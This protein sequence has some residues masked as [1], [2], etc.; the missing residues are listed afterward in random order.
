MGEKLG[1]S[2]TGLDSQPEMLERARERRL[3]CRSAIRKRV[4]LVQGD[5]RSWK[6]APKFDLIVIPCSS[7][8]HVL[9]LDDQIALWRNAWGNLRAGGRFVIEVVMPDIGAF[10]SS[11]G[12][13]PRV[14][15]E[16]DLDNYDEADGIRLIRRKTTRYLSHEQRAEIRFMYEKY[17]HG[18]AIGSFIDDFNS[19]VFFPRELQ[20]LFI[21]TGFEIEPACGDYR[22]RPLGTDSSLIIITGVKRPR[23]SD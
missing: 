15:L 17:Q 7:I 1:F 14:P 2:V 11:T 21:H 12:A 6:A 22:G 23:R 8:T 13:S 19:H 4:D 3:Q 10:A 5:M 16:V 18:Q 20:L 9:G